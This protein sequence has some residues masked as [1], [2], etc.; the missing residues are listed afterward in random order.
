MVCSDGDRTMGLTARQAG[1]LESAVMALAAK[2]ETVADFTAFLLSQFA[3]VGT[4]LTIRT[5][6]FF[7]QC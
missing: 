5:G 1:N 3:A 2:L 7:Q 6:G 4:G